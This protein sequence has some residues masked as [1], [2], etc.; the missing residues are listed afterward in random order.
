[1]I[2]WNNNL[3]TTRIELLNNGYIKIQ[4][5]DINKDQ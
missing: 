4:S 5:T 3:D 1:M 2:K